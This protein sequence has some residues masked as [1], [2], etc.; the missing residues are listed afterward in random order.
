MV[1]TS[2]EPEK[3]KVGA[4]LLVGPFGPEV[5]LVSGAVVS[6]VQV[7]LAGL[8]SVFPAVSVAFTSKVCEPSDS[9]LYSFGE[10][11]LSKAPLSSLHS[12][13][14]LLSLEEKLKLAVVLLRV[15]EGPEVMLVSGEVTT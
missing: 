11:Q 7:R 15:P 5:M 14:A 3:V 4:V 13:V 10:V 6:T 9:P 2:S 12:K 1:V 8:A